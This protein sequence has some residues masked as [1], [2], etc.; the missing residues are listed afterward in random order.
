MLCTICEIE[1]KDIRH[2]V[3][4]K[5]HVFKEQNPIYDPIEAVGIR[6]SI[7]DPDERRRYYNAKSR[8]YY[9]RKKSKQSVDNV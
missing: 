1:I 9:R 2:H 5:S 6:H 7:T 4:T 8:F 3:K